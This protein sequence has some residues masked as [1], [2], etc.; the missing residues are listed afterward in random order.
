M[1]LLLLPST[2]KVDFNMI[3]WIICVAL[4]TK[5]STGLYFTIIICNIRTRNIGYVVFSIEEQ[6][7]SL[8]VISGG[9]TI[10]RDSN[11]DIAF[12]YA[13]LCRKITYDWSIVAVRFIGELVINMIKIAANI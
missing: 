7:I 12:I 11:N 13:C 4:F 1:I 3:K 9:I 5:S 2:G 10:I 8:N 6:N